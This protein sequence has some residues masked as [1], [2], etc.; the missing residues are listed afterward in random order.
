MDLSVDLVLAPQP[1]AILGESL[2]VLPDLLAIRVLSPEASEIVL[3]TRTEAFL[4]RDRVRSSATDRAIVIASGA[5]IATHENL[6]PDQ[7]AR[8]ILVED[9]RRGNVSLLDHQRLVHFA[10][11]VTL[12]T[13]GRKFRFGFRPSATREYLSN[14]QS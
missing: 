14:S 11:R 6:R 8:E 10:S 1:L 9:T 13:V 7:N 5:R 12:S 2:L 4:Q 3:R